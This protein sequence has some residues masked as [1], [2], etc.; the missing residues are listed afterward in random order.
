MGC[1]LL[2]GYPD[3]AIS[4]RVRQDGVHSLFKPIEVPHLLN[5]VDSLLR[6]R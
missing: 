3:A 6:E 2:T 1:V 4:E 5:T